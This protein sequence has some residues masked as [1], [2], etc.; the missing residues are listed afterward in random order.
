MPI[1]A[2]EKPPV[3]HVCSRCGHREPLRAFVY[4]SPFVQING[5]NRSFL[6]NIPG[7]D[8]PREFKKMPTLA[9]IKEI[10]DAKQAEAEAAEQVEP[11][12]PRR[13]GGRPRNAVVEE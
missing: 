5:N 3:E 2:E 6:C 9:E 13:R 12:E 4:P 7:E 11:S 8:A 1:K 10:I